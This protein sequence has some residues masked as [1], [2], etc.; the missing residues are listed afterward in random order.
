MIPMNKIILYYVGAMLAEVA[1][2]YWLA[3][4]TLVQE[5]QVLRSGATITCAL[6]QDSLFYLC[7]PTQEYKWVLHES[8]IN[9]L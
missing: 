2:T 1:I 6:M 3:H 9:F 5:V 4:Q 7:L 8:L